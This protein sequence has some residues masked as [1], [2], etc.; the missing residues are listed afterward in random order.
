MPFRLTQL[1]SQHSS[2]EAPQVCK[3]WWTC[4]RTRLQWLQVASGFSRP[5]TIMRQTRLL[6]SPKAIQLE[7]R[8]SKP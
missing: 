6:Q 8:R 7:P 4:R 2:P 3:M 1:S 5:A